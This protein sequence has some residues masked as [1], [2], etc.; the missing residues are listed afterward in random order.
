MC[1]SLSSSLSI[2]TGNLRSLQATAFDL[3]K[4]LAADHLKHDLEKR[5]TREE[6]VER[7]ASPILSNYS[8]H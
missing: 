1:S 4:K 2:L 8:S 6:L 3:E 5:H 7:M